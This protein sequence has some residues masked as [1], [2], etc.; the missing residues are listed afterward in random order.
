MTVGR[1]YPDK[2]DNRRPAKAIPLALLEE[3]K[4]AKKN[5]ISEIP[6]ISAYKRV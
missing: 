5:Q 2:Q 4:G 3:E 1:D 6:N